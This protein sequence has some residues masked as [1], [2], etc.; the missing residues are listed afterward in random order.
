MYASKFGNFM[1]QSIIEKLSPVYVKGVAEQAMATFNT[2]LLRGVSKKGMEP[3]VRDTA[4]FSGK[5][6]NKLTYNSC[7]LVRHDTAD[8][9]DIIPRAFARKKYRIATSG[10]SFAMDGY[11]QNTKYFLDVLDRSLGSRNTAYIAP[12]AL[13]SGNIY[14][15]TTRVSGISK[16]KILYITCEDFLP[17]VKPENYGDRVNLGKFLRQPIHVFKK[18]KDYPKAIT[19][20]SN[21]L[22]CTGGRAFA[23]DEIVHALKQKHKVVLLLND[24]M[25]NGV[26][27]FANN[28]VENAAKYFADITSPVSGK[29]GYPLVDN[30]DVE[31][32]NAHP[33]RIRN[34]VRIYRINGDKNH[35]KS[36]AERAARFIKDDVDVYKYIPEERLDTMGQS[37]KI[38]P[39]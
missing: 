8:V 11:E 13:D 26:Y 15:M 29:S 7:N 10:Y 20:A 25:N 17:F 12:P 23:I 38:I 16:D 34:F 30:L 35:T 3:L 27:D 5:S 6:A 28:N 22:V 21:V 1:F 31:W 39:Y 2:C 4:E 14:D 37:T 33:S 24:E 32:L 36:I 9:K 18:Q 19:D